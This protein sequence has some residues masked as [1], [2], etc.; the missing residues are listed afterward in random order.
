MTAAKIMPELDLKSLDLP[1]KIA[2]KVQQL[3]TFWMKKSHLCADKNAIKSSNFTIKYFKEFINFPS[4]IRSLILLL[5][6]SRLGISKSN[7]KS[8]MD[9]CTSIV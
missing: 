4:R 3:I 9:L 8:K 2:T 1:A 5:I 6:Q 7:T